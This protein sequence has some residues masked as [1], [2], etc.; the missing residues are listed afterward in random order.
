MVNLISQA[1][2]A[3]HMEERTIAARNPNTARMTKA[4]NL[5]SPSNPATE[6]VME[7]VTEKVT[8]V[9]GLGRIKMTLMTTKSINQVS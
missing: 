4:T 2:E 1:M 9:E 8:T 3:A 6:E 7:E 5:I